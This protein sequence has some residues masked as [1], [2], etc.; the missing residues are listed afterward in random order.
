MATRAIPWDPTEGVDIVGVSTFR[1][2]ISALRRTS[3]RARV[4]GYLIS[5]SAVAV[6][7]SGVVAYGLELRS[8]DRDI[9]GD[10]T[11]RAQS[12]LK[13]AQEG[14][15]ST[16]LP[17]TDA[18]V[19]LYAGVSQVIASPTESAV[20]HA[21]GVP[22]FV[23]KYAQR[24]P[25]ERDEAFLFAAEAH[26]TDQVIV[27][28][29]RTEE[30]LYHYVSVP[31]FD[32]NNNVLG[33]FTVATDR[34]AL[35]SSLN[36]T[37]AL[38]LL[39]GAVALVLTGAVAWVT[40][41]RLLRPITLLDETAKDIS[42]SDL[43]RRIPIVGHDDLARLSHTVNAM[44]DRLENAFATQRQLLDDAGHELRTPLAVM[45][46]NLEL[47][48]PRDSEQ[49]AS[50]QF[51][52]LDEV[53]MM[54]RLVDDL[55]ILAKADRPEFVQHEVLDLGEFTDAA[56][57]RA[58]ALGD[59]EWSLDSRGEGQFEGDGQRLTQAW[60]QL[61]ANAVKFSDPGSPVAVGSSLDGGR[62]RLWVKDAGRGIPP[63]EHERVIERFHRLNPDVEGA[64]LGLPI[65]AAITSAHE[66]HL[67]LESA[68]GVGSLF[69]MVLPMRGSAR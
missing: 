9:T 51:L 56:F 10:L 4:L 18:R 26:P 14:D 16:R 40:V 15:P 39:A 60:M 27:R 58:Q 46:T 42:E 64:G 36:H 47:L 61:V 38:Y 3:V 34:G 49:V 25:L 13:L 20:G 37:F 67:E 7:V 59:R 66:G 69:T 31:I 6:A 28:S 63:D 21:N 12:F 65:V 22:L 1:S 30:A 17:Y 68:P 57:S 44:L 41:G 5:L 48:E 23:P 55:V 52:L 50:T 45:R 19:L 53:A 54:S 2:R 11:L 32:G 33:T 62:V 8:I 35:V 29:V 43:S 24:L